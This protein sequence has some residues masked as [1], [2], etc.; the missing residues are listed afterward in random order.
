MRR[1]PP[2]VHDCCTPETFTSYGFSIHS[3]PPLRTVAVP[4]RPMRD[5]SSIPAACASTPF[6][7]LYHPE[8]PST[9]SSTSHTSFDSTSKPLQPQ[10]AFAMSSAESS[11]SVD[12]VTSIATA[13]TCT[14]HPWSQIPPELQLEVLGYVVTESEPIDLQKIPTTTD[15]YQHLQHYRYPQPILG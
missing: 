12:A 11:E 2:C 8:P 5:P 7:D 4:I 10:P 13:M 3:S 6:L 15:T 14:F 1:H 9:P